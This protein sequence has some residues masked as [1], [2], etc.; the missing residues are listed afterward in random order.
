MSTRIFV[1][2]SS[3]AVR[4]IV[5]QIS[6]PEGFEVVGFQDG[7]AALEAAKRLTPQLIIA[8]YHLDNITFSGFCKEVNKLDTLSETLIVSLIGAADRLDEQ[9]LRTLGVKAFLKKPL[10]SEHLL[11]VIKSLQRNGHQPVVNGTSG[12]RRNWP[13]ETTSTD[14]EELDMASVIADS[15]TLSSEQEEGM[16]ID[17]TTPAP[18][19]STPSTDSKA[20]ELAENGEQPAE[21]ETAMK[22]L[23][24]QFLQSL[25]IQA[26]QKVTELLPDVI[27]RTFAS[28]LE[29]L[30]E[31]HVTK[32]LSASLSS[33][34]LGTQLHDFVQQELPPMLSQE[35]AQQEIAIRQWL[36]EI[37]AP[38]VHHAVDSLVRE[39]V[40][41]AVRKQL[42]E[43]VR[44]QLGSIDLLVKDEIAR[45][46]S[47]QA[48]E[49][50]AGIV[51]EVAQEKVDRLAQQLVPEIAEAQVKEEIKKLS[52]D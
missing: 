39:L 22:G 7:P 29:P 12:K 38:F 14:T 45:A 25:T 27:S 33:E 15:D 2:D 10:Q 9:H 18:L 40:E 50:T 32:Q 49:V 1:V 46:A 34:S 4:R 21:P 24:D 52:S 36:E 51:R 37:A 13:P 43:V 3:P 6:T 19:L 30:V 5:E 35:L 28:Q 41:S 20:T 47:S 17:L 48:Q 42:T 11:D 44:E 8:D 31:E 16:A 26:E 23:F